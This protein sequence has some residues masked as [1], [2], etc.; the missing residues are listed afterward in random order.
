MIMIQSDVFA[1]RKF[2]NS[3]GELKRMYLREPWQGKGIG[4]L[5]L[6][7]SMKQAQ[8]LGYKKLRLDT[9]PSM[10]AAIS[11]Y[12]NAGFYEIPSYRFNPVAGTRYFEA[13][14]SND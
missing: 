2:E 11:L 13:S 14:L 5:M 1:I 10:H 9:L 7:E 6:R 12:R 3:I 8:Q 4:M